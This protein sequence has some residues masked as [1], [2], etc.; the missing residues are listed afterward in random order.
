M[1]IIRLL[2][3]TILVLAGIV[4]ALFFNHKPDTKKTG[5]VEL[6]EVSRKAAQP[7]V[8]TLTPLPSEADIT[9]PQFDTDAIEFEEEV[10]DDAQIEKE[11]ID[12]AIGLISSSKYEERIEGVEKLGAYPNA[13]MEMILGQ[14][15]TTDTNPDVRNAAAL[16]LGSIDL[17]SN[18]TINYLMSVLEDESGDVRFNAL[19]TL[20]DY[21]LGMEQGSISHKL[22]MDELIAKASEQ[23][24]SL[25][26][27]DSINEFLKNQHDVQALPVIS[28]PAL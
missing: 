19:S 24:I 18:L 4:A 14:L 26:V 10:Y 8:S 25:D 7:P 9:Q 11:Q 2:I 21:L 15:L 3:I 27:R 22:I 6:S 28:D 5:T 13:E 20:E 17:P 12:V 16:S 1:S 23:R